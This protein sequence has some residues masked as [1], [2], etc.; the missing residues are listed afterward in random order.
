M[1]AVILGNYSSAYDSSL[2]RSAVI[3][4]F[5]ISNLDS[6]ESLLNSLTSRNFKNYRAHYLKGIIYEKKS[7]Y[8]RAFEVFALLVN[9]PYNKAASYYHLARAEINLDLPDSACAH[10]E[11]ASSYNLME[12]KQLKNLYCK[13]E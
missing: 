8:D 1:G 5:N 11:I 6:A 2:F 12:A 10:L 9:T 7:A 3:L 13:K 4:T